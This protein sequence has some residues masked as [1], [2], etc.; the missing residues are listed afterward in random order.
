MESVFHEMR[1][2][3]TVS[4]PGLTFL[5]QLTGGARLIPFSL[6]S[7]SSG[8]LFPLDNTEQ[9]RLAAGVAEDGLC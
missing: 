7:F 9:G 8:R 2:H 1:F 6:L 3:L 4:G 5:L